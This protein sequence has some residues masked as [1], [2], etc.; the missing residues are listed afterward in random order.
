M[1]D[2]RCV[3]LLH[4]QAA[5]NFQTWTC[6]Q[7]LGSH[8]WQW[9]VPK[10][11]LLYT[12]QTTH[13]FGTWDSSGSLCVAFLYKCF[14]R[15]GGW[16]TV[17]SPYNCSPCCEAQ[18]KSARSPIRLCTRPALTRLV[19]NN[20]LAGGLKANPCYLTLLTKWWVIMAQQYAAVW[21]PDQLRPPHI[22][23]GEPSWE[24][25]TVL[26]PLHLSHRARFRN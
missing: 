9:K 25:T 22:T 12:C 26:L 10:I 11:I 23:V 14:W 24:L 4:V 20:R 7:G 3:T 13:D 15:G 8:C 1:K 16:V 18:I 21:Q 17:S 2:C 19:L 5:Y 6:L